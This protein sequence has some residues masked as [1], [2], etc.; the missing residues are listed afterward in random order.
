MQLAA[1]D[2]HEDAEAREKGALASNHDNIAPA[3]ARAW[4]DDDV[5]Q[6]S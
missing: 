4:L 2:G 1:A 3:H 6:R 5:V